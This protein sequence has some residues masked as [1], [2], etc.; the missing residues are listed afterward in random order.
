MVIAVVIFGMQDTNGR[1]AVVFAIFAMPHC[2][3]CY[4]AMQQQQPQ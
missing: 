3:S 2:F 1:V 4:L